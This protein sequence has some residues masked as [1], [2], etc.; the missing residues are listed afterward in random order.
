MWSDLMRG[1][2]VE[3]AAD[4]V[5]LEERGNVA[6]NGSGMK[7]ERP[8]RAGEDSFYCARSGVRR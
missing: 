4:Q 7:E 3:E 8:W 5:D 2:E 6:W 1:I